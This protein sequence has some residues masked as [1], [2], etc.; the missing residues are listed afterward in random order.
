VVLDLVTTEKSKDLKAIV[1][2]RWQS[3]ARC[4]QLLSSLA[5]GAAS[6]A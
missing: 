2:E 3:P 6:E 5:E 1:T 4:Y